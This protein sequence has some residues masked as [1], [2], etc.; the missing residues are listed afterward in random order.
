MPRNSHEGMSGRCLPTYDSPSPDG[1]AN[2]IPQNP[3]PSLN[4]SQPLHETTPNL[5]LPTLEC[6]VFGC[7]LVFSGKMPYGYLWRHLK[8]PGI[9]GRTGDEKNAWLDLHRIEHDRLLA[10]RITPAQRKRDARKVKAQKMLRTAEFER[11]AR[12]MGIAEEGLVAQKV[13][14]WQGHSLNSGGSQNRVLVGDGRSRPSLDFSGVNVGKAPPTVEYLG[15]HVPGIL[16]PNTGGKNL[17]GELSVHI[18]DPIL[19]SDSNV[20]VQYAWDVYVGWYHKRQKNHSGLREL[21]TSS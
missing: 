14:I 4:L 2:A 13:A 16:N 3:T 18:C 8:H 19:N 6:P 15:V 20:R 10:T 11:R 12:S 5:G 1:N 17:H 9:R 21:G 7:S